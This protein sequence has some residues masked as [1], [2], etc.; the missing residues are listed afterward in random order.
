MIKKLM[1]SVLAAALAFGAV[2]ASARSASAQGPSGSYASGIACVNLSASQSTTI[3]INFYASGSATVAATV[4]DTTPI[5]AG[6][7]RNYFTP[8][9][10][11]LPSGFI[12]SAVVSA[13]QPVA[14]NVN[15]QAVDVGGNPVGTAANLARVDTSSGVD[16]TQAA[17]KLYVPQVLK[18]LGGFNSYIAVQ[19][20]ETTP[21]TVQISYTDRFGVAIP[22]ATESQTIQP[23]SNYVFY[24]ANNAGLPAGFLGGAVIQSTSP[25]TGKVAAVVTMFNDG[26]SSTTAQLLTYTAFTGGANKLYVPRFVRNYY[27]FQGG[28]TIQNVGTSATSATI[29]LTI[30]GNTYTINT[31]TIQPGAAYFNYAP[32]LT[33]LAGVDALAVNARFG[34]GTITAAPGGQIVAIVNEDNRGV[35]NAGCPIAVV[36]SPGWG[37]TYRAVPD[38]TQTNTISFAQVTRRVGSAEYSGGFQFSNT[39]ATATTC[40]I[41]YPNDTDANVSG[42]ALAGNGSVSIFAPSVNNLNDGYNASVVVTCGQPIVGISNLAAR[43]GGFLGDSVTTANGLNR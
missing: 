15:T 17:N 23:Q 35:C 29:S 4:N 16:S 14:C 41:S 21:V 10:S 33:E 40:S 42:V 5:A 28:M 37:S 22:A 12:G 11:G 9:V 2:G 43:N 3:T 39:T 24:Q 13:S 1:Y 7:S 8:S 20:T 34:G 25:S 32:N 38:G 36:N 26:A 31:G 27:G 19:N 6:A 30:G 18:G